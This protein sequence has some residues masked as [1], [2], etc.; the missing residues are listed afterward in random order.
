MPEIEVGTMLTGDAARP[1]RWDITRRA[2]CCRNYPPTGPRVLRIE[3][4][5]PRQLVVQFD[6]LVGRKQN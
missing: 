3:M 5:S 2:I 6:N 4:P 1:V